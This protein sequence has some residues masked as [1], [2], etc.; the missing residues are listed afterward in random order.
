M[1]AGTLPECISI[2]FEPD[3]PETGSDCL[4]WDI[5]LCL[6]VDG[7]RAM[8]PCMEAV[9]ETILRIPGRFM[10]TARSSRP[11]LGS[12]RARLLVFRD[13]ACDG[14]KALEDTG[15]Y[16]LTMDPEGEGAFREAVRKIRAESRAGRPGSGLEA[17]ALAMGSDWAIPAMNCRHVIFL[18]TNGPAMPLGNSFSKASPFYPPDLPV[19]LARMWQGWESAACA[20]WSRLF[21]F[22]PPVSPWTE[23]RDWD[24]TLLL[25][26]A[27]ETW[28]GE[29][30]LDAL[31]GRVL[32]S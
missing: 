21:L 24:R 12:L 3:P 15:F 16:T 20:D 6:V 29:T 30:D 17:L 7:R 19:S 27:A 18:F 22:A 2:R 25:Q 14:E 23:L 28:P 5:D 26:P 10:E 11:G 9:K 1:P 31:F 32:S 4:G 13:F 8:A